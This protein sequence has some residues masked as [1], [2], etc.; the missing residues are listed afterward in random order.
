MQDAFII[1]RGRRW[2][3]CRRH[4]V[5]Q[6]TGTPS[7]SEAS[8]GERRPSLHEPYISHSLLEKGVPV[9]LLMWRVW[10]K[11]TG[12][13]EI[14]RCAYGTQLNSFPF[15]T[16]WSHVNGR[17]TKPVASEGHMTKRTIFE[18]RRARIMP[19]ILECRMQIKE[20]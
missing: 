16:T 17:T 20:F 3:L 10:T 14:V 7:Q 11:H 6:L 9:N 18:G 8:S 5:L 2:N 19:F 12:R 15:F 1:C 4:R 13:R